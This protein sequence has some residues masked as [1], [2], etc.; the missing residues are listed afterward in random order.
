MSAKPQLFQGLLALVINDE[1]CVIT[2]VYN[3][4]AGGRAFK[5]PRPDQT[6]V[7]SKWLA[8]FPAIVLTA[9]QFSLCQKLCQNPFSLGGLCQNSSRFRLRFDSTCPEPPVSSATTFESTS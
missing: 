6:F 7:D 2:N 3:L 4:G 5:S 1:H 8:R 9:F